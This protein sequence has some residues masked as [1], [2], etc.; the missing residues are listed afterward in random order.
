MNRTMPPVLPRRRRARPVADAPVDALLPRAEDLAKGWLLALLEQAPL[1]DAPAILA[2]DLSTDGPRICDAV[3]RA[4]GDDLDL[5]RLESGGTLR[6]LV[7]RT[8]KLAGAGAPATVSRAVDALSAVVWAAMREELRTPDGDLVG[9]LAER[10]ALVSEIV[11]EAALERPAAPEPRQRSLTP[12][13]TPADPEPPSPAKA[14][15]TCVESSTPAEPPARVPS[16]PGL[17]DAGGE[18]AQTL[19]IQALEDEIR[20]A[21]AGSLA[22]LVAELEDAERIIAVEAEPEV[23]L[24]RF[25][26]AVRSAVRRNDI[27]VS[28]SEARAWIIARDTGRAGAFALGGRISDALR[29]SEPWQGAPLV[30]SVGVA[31]LGQDGRTAEELIEA[32]ED[33]RFA[34]QASGVDVF[35]ENPSPTTN[36]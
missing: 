30:A 8:G 34:A 7:A 33:A 31:V 15:P 10:L 13:A 36:A 32:A 29:E 17:G 3:V 19:W 21:D 12:V 20:H 9:Q 4:I 27:L 5:G 18:P 6:A 24:G 1:G 26:A 22:L 23:M 25:A 28:E 14:A 11:R 35:G 2:A 16:W